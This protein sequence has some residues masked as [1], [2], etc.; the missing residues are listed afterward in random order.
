MKE[1][2]LSYQS[3]SRITPDMLVTLRINTISR[4]TRWP[5]IVSQAVILSLYMCFIATYSVIKK[6]N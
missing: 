4:G 2:S 6:S 5:H 1:S 3:R